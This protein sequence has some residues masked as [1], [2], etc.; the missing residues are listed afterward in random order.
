MRAVS[1]PQR[2][3]GAGHEHWHMD[4][5]SK[6]NRN[7]GKGSCC[8]LYDCRPTQ[9]R[10]V[11]DHYEVKVDGEWTGFPM[12]RSIMWWRLMVIRNL[13]SRIGLKQ[14][15]LLREYSKSVQIA[16]RAFKRTG[17]RILAFVPVERS[18]RPRVGLFA[19]LRDKVTSSAPVPSAA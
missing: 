15:R 7:D 4:F 18:L 8:N 2:E 12:T 5:Y 1:T 3:A 16:P 11:G 9:S 14:A 19:P 6:L 10:K 17:A 13:C